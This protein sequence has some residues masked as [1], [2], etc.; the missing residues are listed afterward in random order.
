MSFFSKKRQATL[1]SNFYFL[2]TM[3]MIGVQITNNL[4]MFDMIKMSISVV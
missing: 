3:N 1:I 4:I 2:V